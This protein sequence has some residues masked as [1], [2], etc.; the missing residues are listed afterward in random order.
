VFVT[1]EAGSGETHFY[2]CPECGK[3]YSVH[4]AQDPLVSVLERRLRR[5]LLS[6]ER[7]GKSEGESSGGEDAYVH[8]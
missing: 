4:A 3:D 7:E 6:R 5:R 2:A 1:R 8:S